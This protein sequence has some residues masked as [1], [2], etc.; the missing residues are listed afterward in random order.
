MVVGKFWQDSG[1]LCKPDQYDGCN[2][3]RRDLAKYAR[4]P[5]LHGRPR[6]VHGETLSWNRGRGP[7]RILGM[8]LAQNQEL[9]HHLVAM[10]ILSVYRRGRD[11][12][13]RT[14]QY[15]CDSERLPHT[16]ASLGCNGG[17]QRWA[18][19]GGLSK[20]G[21]RPHEIAL[22]MRAFTR[23]V[24]QSHDASAALCEC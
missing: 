6:R 13:E 20:D 15:R 11:L 8:W 23:R 17:H 4:L 19:S 10:P 16:A 9:H 22:S 14:S 3:Q 18:R 12:H 7:R 21:F 1:G 24:K 2:Q 5:T